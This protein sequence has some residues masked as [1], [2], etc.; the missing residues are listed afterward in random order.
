MAVETQAAQ[1]VLCAVWEGKISMWGVADY[2]AFVAAI[3]VF[4]MDPRAGQRGTDHLYRQ[5][6]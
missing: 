1:T 4:L 2:G 6:W 5:G 3:V